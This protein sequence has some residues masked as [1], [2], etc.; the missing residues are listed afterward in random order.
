[1]GL[2]VFC[3]GWGPGQTG[4]Q[5][6]FGLRGLIPNLISKRNF[7]TTTPATSLAKAGVPGMGVTFVNKP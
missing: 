2:S 3:H 1:M 5:A 7:L 6:N 4:A